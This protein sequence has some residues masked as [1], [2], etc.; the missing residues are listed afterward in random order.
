MRTTLQP[1]G[2]TGLESGE[3]FFS[4]LGQKVQSSFAQIVQERKSFL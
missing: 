2:R 4:L 1:W 3:Y